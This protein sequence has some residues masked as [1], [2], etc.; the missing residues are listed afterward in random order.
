MRYVCAVDIEKLE[1]IFFNLLSNAL[2]YTP[3]GGHIWVQLQ[4][5]TVRSRDM[6][7]LI[8]TDDGPGISPLTSS[9]SSTVSISRSRTRCPAARASGWSW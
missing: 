9:I 7:Q 2:K 4:Q 6:L 5:S 8:I 3:A 1:H